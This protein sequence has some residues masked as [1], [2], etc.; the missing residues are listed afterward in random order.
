M[1][2][3]DWVDIS[4]TIL[5]SA[6]TPKS[7]TRLMYE[8]KLNSTQFKAYFHDFLRKGLLEEADKN[9]RVAY[10]TSERG[11]TLLSVLKYAES[12]FSEAPKQSI[13]HL[14]VI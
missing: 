12:L 14:Q 5:E 13:L 6:K 1:R 8:S 9:G 4:I 3:R 2:K 7:K 10:V 11:R